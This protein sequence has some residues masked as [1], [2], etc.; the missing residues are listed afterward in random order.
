MVVDDRSTHS[1]VSLCAAEPGPCEPIRINCG[2]PHAFETDAFKGQMALWIAGLPDSP[3]NLFAGKK[4]K[5]Y[6]VI[7]VRLT[8]HCRWCP[9]MLHRGSVLTYPC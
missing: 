4:R 9:W 8:Q 1:T 6:L 2:A 5:T 3:V 7:Q